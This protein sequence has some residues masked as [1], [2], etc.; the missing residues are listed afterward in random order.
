MRRI[1]Y[2]TEIQIVNIGIQNVEVHM[3]EE[4]EEFIVLSW[5]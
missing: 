4:L 5:Y 2:A 3:I 1:T